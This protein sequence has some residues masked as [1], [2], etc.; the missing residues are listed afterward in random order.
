MNEPIRVTLR[1]IGIV[2]GLQTVEITNADTGEV[3][4]FN[5]TVVETSGE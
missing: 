5:Q 2:D 3:I 1:D 4:G